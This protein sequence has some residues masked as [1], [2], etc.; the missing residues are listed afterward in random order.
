[1]SLEKT[2]VKKKLKKMK[3]KFPGMDVSQI[4]KEL[5]PL[6]G[7]DVKPKVGKKEEDED[8]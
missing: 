2:Y 7:D 1:M 3:D 5:Y 8:D 6:G 4:E